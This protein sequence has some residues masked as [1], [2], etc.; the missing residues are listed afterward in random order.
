MF[1][2]G[3]VA[4]DFTLHTADGQPVS[5]SETLHNGRNVLLIFLRHLG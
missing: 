1:G 5:L 3:N 2:T 4:P